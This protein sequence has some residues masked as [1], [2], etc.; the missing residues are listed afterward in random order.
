[1][2]LLKRSLASGLLEAM[3]NPAAVIQSL[4]SA[5]ELEHATIPPYLYALYSLDEHKNALI[6][7]IIRSVVI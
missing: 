5:V 1:M 3:P 2:I 6:V 4:Q 7:E